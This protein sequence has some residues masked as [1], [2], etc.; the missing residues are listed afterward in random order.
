M[1]SSKPGVDDDG[2]A[3]TERDERL[4][5]GRHSGK[6]SLEASASEP[7]GLEEARHMRGW[8]WVGDLRELRSSRLDD[9]RRSPVPSEP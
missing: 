7:L 6:P 3:E 2:S 4:Q 9:P 1:A 5:A 8:G